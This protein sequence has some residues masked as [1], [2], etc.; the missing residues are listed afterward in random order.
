[1]YD[2]LHQRS[3]DEVDLTA[4]EIADFLDAEYVGTDAH[5]SGFGAIDDAAAGDITFWEGTDRQ[6]IQDADASIVVCSPPSSEEANAS[7]VLTSNPR[8]DFMKVVREFFTEPREGQQAHPSA[9][10]EPGAELGANCHVGPHAHVSAG[11]SIGDDSYIGASTYID[12]SVHVG[13]RCVIQSSA[14]IGEP[15]LSYR[16]D[17]SGELIREVHAGTVEIGDD[18]A[19]GAGSVVDR[20]MF[21]TTAVGDGTKIGRNAYI[22]H[23]SRVEE[24]VWISSAAVIA[25]SVTVHR[26][27]RIYLGARIAPYLDIGADAEVGMGA[28]VLDDVS[29][30]AR[31]VGSPAK[32]VK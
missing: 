25:G 9:T 2:G 29:P 8:V 28:V 32:P 30:H 13:N 27:A 24:S 17:E 4:E 18:V 22:A 26:R 10:V 21:K 12:G 5:V 15:A 1:M 3:R 16:R 7:Q 19:I 11:A 23:Q 31:V 6:P 20:A 14:S